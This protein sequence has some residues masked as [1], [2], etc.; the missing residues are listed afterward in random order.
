M[1]SS[2]IKKWEDEEEENIT[3]LAQAIFNCTT[4]GEI[5]EIENLIKSQRINELQDRHY[6]KL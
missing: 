5:F 6:K 1:C 3:P 4:I 2:N